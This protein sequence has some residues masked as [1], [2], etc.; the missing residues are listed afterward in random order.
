MAVYLSVRKGQRILSRVD[1]FGFQ[2]LSSPK[3]AQHRN[4][5]LTV[6]E[7]PSFCRCIVARPVCLSHAQYSSHLARRQ[8]GPAVRPFRF[9]HLQ[10]P[11]HSST[12]SVCLLRTVP[13]VAECSRL[14]VALGSSRIWQVDGSREVRARC[15]K[16]GLP[17]TRWSRF[18]V[19]SIR[20]SCSSNSLVV[21]N[22]VA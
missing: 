19:Y 18:L 5:G 20:A 12:V 11:L 15:P 3:P 10:G 2:A 22:A 13:A 8:F 17:K 9:P 4:D 1:P 6:L 16:L 14:W 7:L 21:K